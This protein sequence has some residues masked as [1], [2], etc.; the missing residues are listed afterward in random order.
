MGPYF[1]QFGKSIFDTRYKKTLSATKGESS[2]TTKFSVCIDSICANS[3]RLVYQ[4]T[5]TTAVTPL[6]LISKDDPVTFVKDQK[7][8]GFI[9][10]GI[11][12][13]KY[14]HVSTIGKKR[15]YGFFRLS[16]NEIVTV[17]PINKNT[18][19][20]KRP[21]AVALEVTFNN[22]VICSFIQEDGLVRIAMN[23]GIDDRHRLLLLT[24]CLSLL[25]T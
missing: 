13:A 22:K 8:Q 6:F 4:K 12:P 17:R 19:Y 18:E 24:L 9:Y 25:S 5:K 7:L 23:K 14:F 16:E 1:I 15:G 21:F 20:G 11:D 3:E 10:I 2:Y